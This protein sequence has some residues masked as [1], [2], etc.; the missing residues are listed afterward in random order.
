MKEILEYFRLF[1]ERYWYY[2]NEY[3]PN[4]KEIERLLNDIA[5]KAVDITYW[6]MIIVP[7]AI[8]VFIGVSFCFVFV[9]SF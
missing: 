5:L 6:I 8:F 3:K 9:T 4:E 1:K 7:I 2:F